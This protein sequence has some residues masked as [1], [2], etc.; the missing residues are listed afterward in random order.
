MDDSTQ[1]EADIP[2]GNLT[3]EDLGPDSSGI[4]CSESDTEHID[5]QF[6]S[7]SNTE[8]LG[9]GSYGS[10]SFSKAH[11]LSVS[12][13]TFTNVTNNYNTVSPDFRRIPLGDI[14]LRELRFE[15]DHFV[16]E[17]RSTCQVYAARVEGRKSTATVAIYEGNGSKEEWR[18]DVSRCSYLRCMRENPGCLAMLIRL[19]PRHPNFVQLWGVTTSSRVYAAIFHDDLIPFKYFLYLHRQR[20][21]LTVYIW[22]FCGSD[23][24][25]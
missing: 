9:A 7:N 16:R 13:G 4:F 11:H 21:V 17:R 14:D 22:A 5:A 1:R 12:G 18:E 24:S 8:S 6:T 10:T 19:H 25:V 3:P 20:P 23:Y 2:P 15:R